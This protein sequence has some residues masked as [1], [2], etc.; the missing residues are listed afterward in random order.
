M[1]LK[2]ETKLL[3]PVENSNNGD[4]KTTSFCAHWWKN[5]EGLQV[6]KYKETR[7][8]SDGTFVLSVYHNYTGYVPGIYVTQKEVQF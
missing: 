3:F 8:R 6:Y 5:R 7:R 1:I 4:T 2:Q